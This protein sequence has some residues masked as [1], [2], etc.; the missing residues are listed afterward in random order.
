MRYDPPPPAIVGGWNRPDMKHLWSHPPTEELSAKLWSTWALALVAAAGC[1]HGSNPQT[2]CS[3]P[4]VAATDEPTP[5]QSEPVTSRDAEDAAR[6]PL[7]DPSAADR[8]I[9]LAILQ[10]HDVRL[11][12]AAHCDGAGPFSDETTIGAYF[13][14]VWVYHIAQYAKNW[15]EIERRALESGNTFV[16]VMIL[17]HHENVVWS[18]GLGF[19]LDPAGNVLRDTFVCAGSG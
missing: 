12:E 13:A 10:N 7:V 3:P 19:E 4:Q 17:S 9:L 1:A 14:G 11:S 18:Q 6:S 5:E 16:L 8:D 15:V 2:R